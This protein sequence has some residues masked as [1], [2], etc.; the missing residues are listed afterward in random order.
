MDSERPRGRQRS[1]ESHR[2]ILAATRALLDEVGYFRLTVEGVAARAG[3]GKTTVV[4]GLA[5]RIAEG[6]RDPPVTYGRISAPS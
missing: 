6:R 4:L 2:A 1:P 5:Q 3:V